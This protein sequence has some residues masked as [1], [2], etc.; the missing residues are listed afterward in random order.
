MG[1]LKSN[2]ITKREYEVLILLA[3]GC[4]NAEIADNLYLSLSPVKTHVSH[5]FQKLN[6]KNRTGA[7]HKAKEI[8]LIP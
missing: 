3:W 8:Q 4:T 5:L 7:L 2:G 6:V 1:Q